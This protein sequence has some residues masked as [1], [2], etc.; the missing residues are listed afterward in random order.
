MGQHL[1]IDFIHFGKTKRDNKS[2]RIARKKKQRNY[3]WF[4]IFADDFVQR[5]KQIKHFENRIETA[6]VSLFIW[7]Q[8]K[9]LCFLTLKSRLVNTGVLFG[10]IKLLVHESNNRFANTYGLTKKKIFFFK[11]FFKHAVFV[12]LC[13]TEYSVFH[14]V[15]AIAI[16]SG[17]SISFSLLFLFCIR[18][19]HLNIQTSHW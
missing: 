15:L 9:F 12:Y 2:Y 6:C 1:H 14:F 10:L 17:C 13:G 16:A 4:F 3:S 18:N 19:F 8:T 5:C 7:S 11:F